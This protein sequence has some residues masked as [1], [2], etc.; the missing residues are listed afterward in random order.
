MAEYKRPARATGEKCV[1][2]ECQCPIR[3]CGRATPET[4]GM[5]R[6]D[7]L[8]RC[9]VC[10]E[11]GIPVPPGTITTSE[12]LKDFEWSPE[13]LADAVN[14]AMENMLDDAA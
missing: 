7:K 12:L 14:Y 4:K 11:K 1:I 9:A 5:R 10:R 13:L 8:G 3:D 6:A 2:P